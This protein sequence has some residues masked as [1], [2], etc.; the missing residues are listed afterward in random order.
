MALNLASLAASA[1][2]TDD[3]IKRTRN[4]SSKFADNPL[5]PVVREAKE[6]GKTVTLPAVSGKEAADEVIPFVRAAAKELGIGV[7]FELPANYAELDKVRVKFQPGEKRAYT[8]R[9]E[10]KTVECPTCHTERSLTSDGTIRVHGP[11]DNRCSGS[12][13]VPA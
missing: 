6:N 3:E 12:G 11:R 13:Q 7:K 8:A 1:K 5:L 10:T 2:M 9:Q 4:A